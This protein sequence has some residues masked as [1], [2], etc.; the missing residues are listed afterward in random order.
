M[1][2][3]ILHDCSCTPTAFMYARNTG[4]HIL[5]CGHRH[6]TTHFTNISVHSHIPNACTQGHTR[7]KYTGTEQKVVAGDHRRHQMAQLLLKWRRQNWLVIMEAYKLISA[8]C[9][10]YAQRWGRRHYQH[11]PMQEES[12]WAVSHGN[13]WTWQSRLPE[14]KMVVEWILVIPHPGQ[15]LLSIFLNHGIALWH[16]YKQFNNSRAVMHITQEHSK[17]NKNKVPIYWLQRCM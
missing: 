1:H 6:T 17:T 16:M 15:P 9:E 13:S 5:L 11:P 4:T 12:E 14:W 2:R 3:D 7:V 10:R 8:E